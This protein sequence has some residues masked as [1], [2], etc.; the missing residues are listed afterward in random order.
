[1]APFCPEGRWKGRVSRPIGQATV[2]FSAAKVTG[3]PPE[4]R[5]VE[6]Q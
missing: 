2:S 4:A 6:E 5:T 1:M 3:K